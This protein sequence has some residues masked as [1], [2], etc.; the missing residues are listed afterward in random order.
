MHCQLLIPGL[1][2]YAGHGR[3]AS[4]TE[5]PTL[6]KIIARGAR[7]STAGMNAESWLLTQ[8]GVRRQQDWPVAPLTLLAD[9]ETAG[10][11]YWLR[12]DPSHFQFQ[13]HRVSVGNATTLDI[14]PEEATAVIKSLNNHFA[15][16]HLMFYAPTPERWYVRLE[17]AP[18]LRTIPAIEAANMEWAAARPV[19]RDGATWRRI[20]NEIQMLLHT[21][22]INATREASGKLALNALWPWGGGVLPKSLNQPF[23][24]IIADDPLAHGLA[25]A[26]TSPWSTV[27]GNANLWL[28]TIKSTDTAL[29]VLTSLVDHCHPQNI[30]SCHAEVAHLEQ[31]W[32][33][34]LMRALQRGTLHRLT[35]HLPDAHVVHHITLNRRNRWKIWCRATPINN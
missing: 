10:T 26:S 4:R 13:Q 28:A 23:H 35:L 2:P 33:A 12:A 7:H 22:S 32:L 3:N 30:P 9:G 1:V 8:F 27:P 18:D 34:P 14:Q 25:L 20:G 21:H 24:S 15:D 5:T 31:H 16:D 6:N 19:G 29:A 11:A 17:H